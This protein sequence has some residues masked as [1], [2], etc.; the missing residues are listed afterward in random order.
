MLWFIILRKTCVKEYKSLSFSSCTSSTVSWTDWNKP[1]KPA[2][3]SPFITNWWSSRTPKAWLQM[4]W[5]LSVHAFHLGWRWHTYQIWTRSNRLPKSYV[6]TS[7][8]KFYVVF[9]LKDVLAKNDL[10]LSL[11]DVKRLA[12]SLLSLEWTT[13]RS[14][15]S[16]VRGGV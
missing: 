14:Q 5:Y 12:S 4:Y 15:L 3:H 10:N 6:R 9:N 2:L 16:S 8:F 7:T 13:F 11:W 1:R